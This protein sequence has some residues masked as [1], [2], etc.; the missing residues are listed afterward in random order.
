MTASLKLFVRICMGMD[1][2]L[3]LRVS[4]CVVISWD[5]PQQW[6]KAAYWALDRE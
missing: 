5:L 1:L 6:L 3:S 2:N 4:F